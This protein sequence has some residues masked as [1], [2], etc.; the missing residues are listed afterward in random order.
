[1]SSIDSMTVFALAWTD[2]RRRRRWFFGVWL[3]GFLL[4]AMLASLLSALSLDDLAFVIL[5]PSW[6]IAFFI[7]G[8][9]LEFFRCPSCQ[10]RFFCTW[11]YCNLFARR[12]VHCGL[13]K[14]S[15]ADLH[16]RHLA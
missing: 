4:V 5:G 12:C 14:W 7:V 2:Y 16:E 6:G 3:G 10:R 1:M 15:E 13:P 8:I 11:W 9:R